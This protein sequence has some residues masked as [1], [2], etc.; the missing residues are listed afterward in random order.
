MFIA[1][2]PPP[3][4]DG[5]LANIEFTALAPGVSPLTFS[6]VFSI[7]RTRLRQ[8]QRSDHGDPWDHCD[9]NPDG[10]GGDSLNPADRNHVNLFF[11]EAKFI[12]INNNLY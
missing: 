10:M 7:F 8:C 1:I 5:V 11:E 3:S 6:N 12:P 2:S 9:T 4:G